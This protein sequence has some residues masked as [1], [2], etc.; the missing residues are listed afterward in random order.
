MSTKEKTSQICCS[1][2]KIYKR[3]I[4]D[5]EALAQILQ[6]DTTKSVARV[7]SRRP[8]IA[9]KEVEVYLM[10]DSSCVAA[11]LSPTITI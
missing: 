2:S 5:N 3:S 1:K 10:G 8:E 4:P 6:I 9:N 7:L 11:M